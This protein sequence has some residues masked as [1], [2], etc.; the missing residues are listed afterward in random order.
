MAIVILTS[1][2]FGGC[3]VSRDKPPE[4]IYKPEES[5]VYDDGSDHVPVVTRKLNKELRDVMAF[6]TFCDGQDLENDNY[7]VALKESGKI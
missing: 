5:E 3:E 2:L 1:A 6:A 4:E 7:V